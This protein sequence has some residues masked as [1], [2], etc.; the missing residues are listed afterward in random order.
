MNSERKLE[1][2]GRNGKT[3]RQMIELFGDNLDEKIITNGWGAPFQ[4]SAREV[5]RALVVFDDRTH[6]LRR[7]VANALLQRIASAI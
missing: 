5:V 6:W 1:A 2:I 3:L 4:A 7:A